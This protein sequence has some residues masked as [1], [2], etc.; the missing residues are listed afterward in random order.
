[1][2]PPGRPNPRD[3]PQG[4]SSLA[5]AAC[6]L[7]FLVAACGG[8]PPPEDGA[9]D[10]APDTVRGT[11]RQVGSTP[12]T[13]V[14]VEGSD[15]VTVTGRL[16]PEL[17]RLSGAR[18]QVTGSLSTGG[19]PG[20]TVDVDRYEILSIDGDRP[21]TGVLRADENG[22]YLE[23]EGRE[24]LRLGAATSG[25]RS[26]VGAKVWVV[27]GEDGVVRRYGVLRPPGQ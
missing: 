20:P 13:R 14:V 26:Q 10:A 6:A 17:A 22:L 15:T 8:S 9:P 1:M 2:M 7:G 24:P 3:R 18:V 19:F 11:V 27:T 12:F 4:A 16:E 23:R 21:A 25:F 5:G